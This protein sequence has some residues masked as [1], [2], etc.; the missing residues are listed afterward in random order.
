PSGTGSGVALTA[1]TPTPSTLTCAPAILGKK[2]KEAPV[3]SVP[4]ARKLGAYEPGG[5]AAGTGVA[6]NE[7]VAVA[8]DPMEDAAVSAA[9]NAVAPE[10]KEIV[11]PTPSWIGPG[12][13]L[14]AWSEKAALPPG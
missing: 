10:P 9:A 4:T 14:R 2:S 6:V 3:W 12:P 11:D 1:A 5:S 13:V 8:P 7:S